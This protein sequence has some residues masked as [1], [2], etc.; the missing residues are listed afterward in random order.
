MIFKPLSK[1]EFE[2]L[3]VDE[4]MDYLH[5]LMADLRHKLEETRQQADRMKQG[6]K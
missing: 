4:R 2:R 6:A 1:E 3:S 5:R